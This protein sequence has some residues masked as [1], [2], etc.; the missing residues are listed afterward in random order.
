MTLT[1]KRHDIDMT[2]GPILANIVRFSLP[3]LAGN[4]FQQLYNTAVDFTLVLIYLHD[5]LGFVRVI[6]DGCPVTYDIGTY[7]C[8][9][10]AHGHGGHHQ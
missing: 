8:Q 1:K 9:Q 6:V 2:K 10:G 5:A 3:L 7:L 4:L